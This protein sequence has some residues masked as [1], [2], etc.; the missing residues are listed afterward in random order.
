M[1]LL[2][3]PVS[4]SFKG[5]M[6][7]YDKKVKMQKNV[8]TLLSAINLAAKQNKTDSI[9]L[10]E[11]VITSEAL[12]Q[13][14][15]LWENVHF[16]TR[17]LNIRD[18]YCLRKVDRGSLIGYQ[19]RHIELKMI[20]LDNGWDDDLK[21]EICLD[22]DTSGKINFFTLSLEWHSVK[23]ILNY[24]EKVE[25]IGIREGLIIDWCEQLKTAYCKKD[26]SFL[27][28]IY[29]PF[30]I[31]VVGRQINNN[32]TFTTL[33]GSEYLKRLFKQFKNIK[34]LEVIFK[35]Y[36]IVKHPTDE[37]IYVV[38]FKQDWYSVNRNDRVYKDL[39]YVCLVWDFSDENS[40]VIHYR[41]WQPIETQKKDVID[42]YHPELQIPQ[43]K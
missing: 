19:V 21:Q 31:V 34:S 10:P 14:N 7:P 27:R 22:F 24:G 30:A 8:E 6:V 15:D 4:F 39:G 40:P 32:Q 29:S 18:S 28:K 11:S 36:E 3:E 17:S 38:T 43:K 35:D 9:T 13:I 12:T 20:P 2:A 1:T 16:E 23:K 37:S 42:A 26:T 5:G 25:E 41:S 33:K